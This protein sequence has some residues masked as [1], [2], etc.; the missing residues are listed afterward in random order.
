MEE[1]MEKKVFE[2]KNGSYHSSDTNNYVAPAELTVT[3]TLNEYRD[4]VS[5]AANT[6]AKVDEANKDKYKREDEIKK[7][8]EKVNELTSENT[9]LKSQ[10]YELQKSSIAEEKAQKYGPGTIMYEED[11]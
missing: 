6:K 10:L 11:T 7:L 3:I 1:S 8:T 9:D 5:T 2:L 4:L